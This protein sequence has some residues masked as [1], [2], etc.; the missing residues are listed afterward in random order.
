MKNHKPKN[1]PKKYSNFVY[2][3]ALRYALV[4][5]IFVG[6]SAA[7]FGFMMNS[8]IEGDK[9]PS[10]KEIALE[11][12]NL[13]ETYPE[14]SDWKRLDDFGI[15][16][17]LPKTFEQFKADDV[18]H[19]AKGDVKDVPYPLRLNIDLYT[20]LP[21]TLHFLAFDQD[22]YGTE[23]IRHIQIISIPGRSD[24]LDDFIDGLV[25]IDSSDTLVVQQS[26]D[27]HIGRYSGKYFITET[28]VGFG[29][30]FAT[31]H[32]FISQNGLFYTIIMQT[33]GN[34]IDESKDIMEKL[35]NT[36]WIYSE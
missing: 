16:L 28:E 2:I 29:F 3:S 14:F 31:V 4:L 12:A 32:Y 13:L 17:W 20:R 9:A 36:L 19:M 33:S 8:L 11:T 7:F 22:T 6:G 1:E 10:P 21:G 34:Q 26:T 18:L 35:M 25:A 27:F 30:S 23:Y 24:M 5:V 15:A